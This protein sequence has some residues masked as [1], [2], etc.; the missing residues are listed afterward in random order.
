[1]SPLLQFNPTDGGSTSLPN[2][3][4]H[5]QSYTASNIKTT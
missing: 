2:P 1:M 3:V 5:S 4:T